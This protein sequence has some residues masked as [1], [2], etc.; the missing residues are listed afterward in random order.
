M[1]GNESP[2]QQGMDESDL[3]AAELHRALLAH[4]LDGFPVPQ[5]CGTKISLGE[6]SIHAA[7]RLACILGA[8]PG[9]VLLDDSPDWPESNAVFGKLDAVLK[10]TDVGVFV[11]MWLHLYCRR[12]E[13]DSGIELGD[14]KLDV[15]GR[16]VKALQSAARP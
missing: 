8:P 12:C 5:G 2:Q 4:D 15:A 11:G 13:G 9:T 3:L 14:I 6:V 7:D 10:A 16:F 1:T